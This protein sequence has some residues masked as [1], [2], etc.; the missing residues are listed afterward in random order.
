MGILP[1]TVHNNT[2]RNIMKKILFVG[3]HGILFAPAT[4]T[5]SA[6]TDTAVPAADTTEISAEEKAAMEALK[7]TQKGVDEV[8]MMTS[9]E[10]KEYNKKLNEYMDALDYFDNK[11][12]KAKKSKGADARAD[13][14]AEINSILETPVV[15]PSGSVDSDD[16][17]CTIEQALT[18]WYGTIKVKVRSDMEKQ[19]GDQ[20]NEDGTVNRKHW[21][22]L[23][24]ARVK[25][26]AL[27]VKHLKAKFAN[28]QVRPR[29]N[30]GAADAP[31]IDGS[32]PQA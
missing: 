19:E 21:F 17:K 13:L 8:L 26:L 12:K 3:T 24:S 9:S 31:M 11:S 30:K 4:D 20:V 22:C 15:L 10:R 18:G 2:W 27:Q 16:V 1:K 23:P 5:A 28:E 25:Q 14:L 32:A 29:K 6:P 7:F